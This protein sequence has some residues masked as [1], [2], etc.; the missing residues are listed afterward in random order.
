MTSELSDLSVGTVEGLNGWN[1]VIVR[2]DRGEALVEGCEREGTIEVQVLPEEN[3]RHLKDASLLKKRRALEALKQ[4]GEL[5]GGYLKL[6]ADLVRKI[7][8]PQ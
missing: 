4:R 3:L 6:S 5:E 7:L 1:T 8:S 2:S